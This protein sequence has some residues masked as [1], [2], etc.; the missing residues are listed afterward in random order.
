MNSNPN[1]NELNFIEGNNAIFISHPDMYYHKYI[2]AEEVDEINK[3]IGID[4]F[5][6]Y[7]KEVGGY[8][9]DCDNLLA[10]LLI[11]IAVG[12]FSSATY[13]LLKLAVVELVKTMKK[14]FL[15]EKEKTYI[16]DF[17]VN[18]EQGGFSFDLKVD[19]NATPEEIEGILDKA[20][21][22]VEIVKK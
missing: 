10:T 17:Q 11:P 18:D 5:I 16:L 14:H 9:G 15:E 6:G 22:I 3:L 1:K 8:G 13:D 20:K 21:A 7:S 12:V 4:D 2:T 19:A